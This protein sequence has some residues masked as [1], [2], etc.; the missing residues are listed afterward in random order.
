MADGELVQRAKLLL[1]RLCERPRFAGSTEEATAR[2]ICRSELQNAGFDCIDRPFEFSE[3]PARWGAPLSSALQAA[4]ILVV[5]RTAMERSP[6]LAIIVA[7]VLLATLILVDAYAKRRWITSF[8][9]RRARSVNLEAK[10]G[11]PLVWLVA[12]L[13]SKSQT[14]PMLIRIAGSAALALMMIVTILLLVLALFGLHRVKALWPAVQI[15]AI[16]AALPGLACYIRNAS[17]GAVDN[18]T[19]VVAV[20][21][22]AQSRSAPH[23]VGVLITS[24]EE[25]GLAGARAWAMTAPKEIR[26]LNCDTVDDVG[27]W[28][29]MYTGH[30]PEQ[31]TQSARR[32]ADGFGVPLRVARLIPGILADNMP[33]ADRGIDAITL[34]RGT[35]ATLS[36]I[37][38]RR[39]ISIA[40][41]GKGPAQAGALLS[42]LSKELA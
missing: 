29:C 40:L 17:L 15:V 12:H 5:A 9:S 33:F 8:P 14:V 25:L 35:L 4:T 24:G 32:V 41:T 31:L 34:S 18:A 28:R 7:G 30:K 26:I 10:R 20:M 23:D 16:V 2:E 27:R 37:H 3:W 22:A 36:R 38:T 21:L 13:D 19:G 1:D 6:L 11:T 39:D 42:A